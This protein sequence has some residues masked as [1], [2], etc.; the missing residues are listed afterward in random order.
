MQDLSD[1]ERKAILGEVLM[2]EIKAIREY[3]E[4]LTPVRK[5]VE[6]LKEDVAELRIDR[7]WIKRML[8]KH[9]AKLED[10]DER[11]KHLEATV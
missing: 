6:K 11:L 5:D 4:Y 2:D 7:D 1:E 9:D 10:H 8:A 3:L